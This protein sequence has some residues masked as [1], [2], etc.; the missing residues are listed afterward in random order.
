MYYE[1]VVR[2]FLN[3]VGEVIT[4]LDY[5]FVKKEGRKLK[6]FLEPFEGA[7]CVSL[8]NVKNMKSFNLDEA[9]KLV[10][11]DIARVR[12]LIRRG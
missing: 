8:K 3:E 9:T 4:K 7:V 10:C 12:A 5:I 11:E 2:K 6:I 1:V